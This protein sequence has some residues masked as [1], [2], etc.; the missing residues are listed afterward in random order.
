MLPRGAGERRP[1]PIASGHRPRARGGELVTQAR[2]R[3]PAQVHHRVTDRPRGAPRGGVRHLGGV[4]VR[5]PGER[6]Q[7]AATPLEGELQHASA[8]A[9]G[10]RDGR[11]AV[12]VR[13]HAHRE[14]ER[15]VHGALPPREVAAVPRGIQG[16]D[17]ARVARGVVLE[18]ERAAGVCVERED[19]ARGEGAH[20]A[21]GRPG[22]GDEASGGEPRR[23]GRAGGVRDACTEQHVGVA[24][25]DEARGVGGTGGGVRHVER[26]RPAAVAREQEPFPVVRDPRDVAAHAGAP[27]REAV[28]REQGG[29]ERGG[30]LRRRFTPREQLPGEGAQL[31]RLAVRDDR[32]AAVRGRSSRGLAR[33]E[34][35]EENVMQLAAGG[36][37]ERMS[38]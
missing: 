1:W 5:L 18:R 11:R 19:L 23:A 33:G 25:R 31:A 9:P 16:R 21:P 7:R 4:V 27:P 38:A 10:E 32:P 35:T 13:A 26:P 24:R 3:G 17:A 6:H 37:A 20:G 36:R 2:E 34:L 14:R 12:R 28:R 30:V 15:V 8:G 29:P 22:R